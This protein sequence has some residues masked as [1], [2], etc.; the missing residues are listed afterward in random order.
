MSSTLSFFVLAWL[1]FNLLMA[2][3]FW[4]DPLQEGR[5][6]IPWLIF[7]LL[8]GPIA[9]TDALARRQ[10]LIPQQSPKERMAILSGAF[11]K[12]WAYY[13]YI[14]PI[15]LYF[16]AIGSD[17]VAGVSDPMAHV[18]EAVAWGLLTYFMLLVISPFLWG[19]PALIFWLIHRRLSPRPS[20]PSSR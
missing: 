10:G 5:R 20:T 8:L 19:I 12:A 14:F 18:L 13:V 16:L 6:R 17:L 3:L 15:I 11:P 7:F 4:G 2:G 9:V 1:L